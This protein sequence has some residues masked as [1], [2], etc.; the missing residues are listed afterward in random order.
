MGDIKL[1]RIGNGAKELQGSSAAIEKSLQ[2]LIV[3]NHAL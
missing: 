3:A 1:F 2:T